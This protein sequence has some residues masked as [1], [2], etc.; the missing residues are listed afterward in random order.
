MFHMPVYV[1]NTLHSNAFS[2]WQ[3]QPVSPVVWFYSLN[4]FPQNG[5]ISKALT[6]LPTIHPWT[7]PF[8]PA[9]QII[10]AGTQAVQGHLCSHS[11]NLIYRYCRWRCDQSVCAGLREPG[12]NQENFTDVQRWLGSP[13]TRWDSTVNAMHRQNILVSAVWKSHLSPCIFEFLFKQMI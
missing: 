3:H 2:F 6:D 12:L 7:I 9:G 8:C 13:T 1:S 10:Q 4:Q 11:L 5:T